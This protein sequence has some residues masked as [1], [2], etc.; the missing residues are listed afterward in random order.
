MGSRF[1]QHTRSATIV[2]F[3]LQ[4]TPLARKSSLNV[5]R[6]VFFGRPL[7]NNN[8]NKEIYNMHIVEH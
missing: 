8:N 2:S 1:R 4:L 6:Q 7:N 3:S 5:D